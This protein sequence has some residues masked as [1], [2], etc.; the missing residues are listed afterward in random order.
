MNE[1]SER[2]FDEL[3]GAAARL[4]PE[5]PVVFAYLFGSHAAGR[6]H[7]FSDVDVAVLL[8]ESVMQLDY[9]DHS[10]ELAGLLAEGAS[11]ANVEAV[12]VLNHAPLPL[13]GR[14]IQQRRVLYSRDEPARVRFESLKLRQFFDFELTMGPLDRRFL[15]DIASGRR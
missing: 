15:E 4:L 2:V 10:L 13:V 6:P 9:L 14:V 5:T 12:L 3:K 11:V 7:R 8:E 1:N